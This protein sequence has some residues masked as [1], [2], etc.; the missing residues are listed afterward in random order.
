[1]LFHV[2][3][4]CYKDIPDDNE[5]RK[6]TTFYVLAPVM[7]MYII[8]VLQNA[9]KAQKKKLYFLA[10]D[11]YS[12]YV[13]AKTICEKA[14]LPIECKYLYCSRYT[15]R[16]AEYSLLG[17]KCLEYICLG[18]IDVT[19]QKMMS[20]AG[21][22]DEEG[23]EIA[24]LLGKEKSYKDNLSYQQVK[25]LQPV[26]KECT[27][28]M[29]KVM[30]NSQKCYPTVCA[31]LKQ[32]GLLE[33][34][35]WAIVDSGWMGSMQKTLEKLLVS[36]G[37]QGTVEGYYYGMYEY[38]ANVTKDSYHTWYFS[39]QKNIGK[40]VYFSNSLFE[41]IF[42]AADAMTIGYFLNEGKYQPVFEHKESANKDK[43]IKSS[44]YLRR[45]AEKLT[46]EY[47]FGIFEKT[48]QHD[49]MTFSLLRLFMGKP[50]TEEAMEFGRYI[51]CDDVIGEA[52][53][54][55]AA[56]LA[57]QDIKNNHL[58]NK[59]VNFLSKNGV[60]I[61]E[62]AWLEGSIVIM[63]KAVRRELWHCAIYKYI[64]YLRKLVK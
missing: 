11:G 37:Y 60:P 4:Q 46:T 39:P 27:S 59:A 61:R 18:G 28:F 6:I 24:V 36:M 1:M 19:F 21:L 63:G 25:E 23:Y 64:L 43:I 34:S 51:F 8:W 15:W 30:L 57:Y 35:D 56:A 7:S 58:I 22:S 49:K 41:C 45:Y 53:Q 52:N 29:D 47:G 55:V 5:T 2:S 3:E 13:M 16:C 26:L 17:E 33:K 14:N 40:K 48:K 54:R 12:M 42:S 9:M 20:R 44:E 31:Y 10:R 32:E 50:T 62:S 38:P